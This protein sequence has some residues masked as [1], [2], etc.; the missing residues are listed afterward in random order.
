MQKIIFLFISFLLSILFCYRASATNLNY[1][2]ENKH[3]LLG[4]SKW[5]P[6]LMDT[7]LS[8]LFIPRDDRIDIYDTKEEKLIDAIKDVAGIKSIALAPELNLG[9]F[10]NSKTDS[11]IIFDYKTL[12]KITNITVNNKP[13]VI[14]YDP[15]TKKLFVSHIASK[16]ISVI[17][18]NKKNELSNISFDKEIK[19]MISDNKGKLFL[20]LIDNNKIA[21]LDTKKEKIIAQYNISQSCNKPSGIAQDLEK[22]ILFITCYNKVMVVLDANNGEIISN[23]EIGVHSDSAAYDTKTGL[24]FSSNGDGTLTI[25]KEDEQGDYRILQNLS[26]LHSA[27]LMAL[28]PNTH[29]IYLL[30][31][32]FDRLEPPSINNPR[33]RIKIKE[34]SVNLIT[35]SPK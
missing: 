18:I 7:T 33:P 14:S 16:Q 35:I 29:K 4:S 19:S 26:T 2:I 11:I 3:P 1:H 15:Y 27:H 24:I 6:L 5:T 10:S 22:N 30:A 20:T 34:N 13:N 21:K 17:D 32:Q 25:A 23:L 8:R 31:G 28:D 9:F 12:K